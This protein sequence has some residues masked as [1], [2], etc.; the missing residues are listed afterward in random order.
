[1]SRIYTCRFKHPIFNF[2]QYS[3]R[4]H[5]ED[6]FAESFSIF[7]K[8]RFQKIHPRTSIKSTLFVRELPVAGNGIADLVVFGWTRSHIDITAGLDELIAEKPIIRAIEFKIS[9]WRRGL[10]QTHRYKHFSDASILVI[11]SSKIKTA[12]LHL[13]TFRTLR[14]GLWGYDM[15]RETIRKAYTPRPKLQAVGKYKTAALRKAT[16]CLS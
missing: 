13:D 15:E 6:E 11:P 14:I 5:S 7:Y 2:R 3:K 1:M 4:R 9:D 10:M 16:F 12:L 8:N